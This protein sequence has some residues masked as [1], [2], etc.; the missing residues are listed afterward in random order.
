MQ[1]NYNL[2]TPH[3]GPHPPAVFTHLDSFISKIRWR[4]G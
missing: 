4:R 3:S 1:L 2:R